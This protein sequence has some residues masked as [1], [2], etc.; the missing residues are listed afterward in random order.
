[1]ITIIFILLILYLLLLML[2]IFY[3]IYVISN[4]KGYNYFYLKNN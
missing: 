1:M 4:Y 3:D 2:K